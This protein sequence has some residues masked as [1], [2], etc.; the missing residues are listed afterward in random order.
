[1]VQKSLI[2]YIV[3]AW[4][5]HFISGVEFKLLLLLRDEN[6]SYFILQQWVMKGDFFVSAHNFS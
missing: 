3:T 6:M 5:F 4:Y 2:S 1:M